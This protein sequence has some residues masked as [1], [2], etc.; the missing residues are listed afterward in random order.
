MKITARVVNRPGEHAATVTTD[1]TARS[2]EIAPDPAGG[3]SV[4]GGE[5]LFLA[6]ATCYC[7][8]VYREA[9]RRDIRIDRVEVD[10]SGTFGGPGDPA[11]EV[12]YGVRVESP[13]N[14][15][16]VEALLRHVDAVAEIQNTVRV[17]TRI[18][19]DSIEVATPVSAADA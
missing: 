19:L 8:D 11:H 3:S 5:L 1:G 16:I 12:R 2:I 7:N 9:G 14:R 15:D 10:V 4:N 6:L 13:E 18:T 17:A